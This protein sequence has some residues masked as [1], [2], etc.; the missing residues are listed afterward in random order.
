[1]KRTCGTALSVLALAIALPAVAGCG[2]EKAEASGADV[3]GFV[4]VLVPLIASYNCPGLTE[5]AQEFETN[6]SGKLDLQKDAKEFQRFVDA[7]PNAI[8]DDFQ[9]FA[10][11]YSTWAVAL[12]RLEALEDA[13]LA[14]PSPEKLAKLRGLSV[15][16]DRHE[17]KQATHNIVAW[18][19]Q[20]CK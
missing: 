4:E 10:D 15:G 18:L 17:L 12:A 6:T 7:A 16:V 3:A 11:A 1:M 2:G 19:D 8:Q 9:T 14:N 13:D 20:N 5:A